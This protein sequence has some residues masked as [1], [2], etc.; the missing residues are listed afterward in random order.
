MSMIHLVATEDKV[1]HKMIFKKSKECGGG[2]RITEWVPMSQIW[3]DLSC[4]IIN[5]SYRL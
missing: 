2:G 3:N 5:D 4:K 1:V